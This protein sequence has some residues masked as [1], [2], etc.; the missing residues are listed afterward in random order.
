[1]KEKAVGAKDYA[2]E[3]A[4]SAAEKGRG[5]FKQSQSSK[6]VEDVCVN[7]RFPRSETAE[8]AKDMASRGMESAKERGSKAA[9]KGRGSLFCRINTVNRWFY[10]NICHV[11]RDERIG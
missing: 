7:F 1:M 11:I 4:S 2:K 9:D 5:T 6:S 8:S 10:R 3:T